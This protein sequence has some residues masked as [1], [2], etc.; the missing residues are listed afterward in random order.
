MSIQIL[1]PFQKLIFLPS[2][3]CVMYFYKIWILTACEVCKYFLLHC[4]NYFLD[5][6]ALHR[7]LIVTKSN[8]FILSFV[9][10]FVWYI[11]KGL[12]DLKDLAL[13][14]IC[15]K[16]WCLGLIL[17]PLFHLKLNFNLFINNLFNG[18]K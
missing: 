14:F 13:C 12:I 15:R 4:L 6:C 16:L 7:I 9:A 11:S 17:G 2:C 10:L 1:D 3:Y 5:K 18:H 8:L